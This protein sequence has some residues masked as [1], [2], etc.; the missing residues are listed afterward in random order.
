MFGWLEKN[1]PF[2]GGLTYFDKGHFIQPSYSKSFMDMV[3]YGLLRRGG[4]DK[5]MLES[6]HWRFFEIRS[7]KVLHSI[8]QRSFPWKNLWKPKVLTKVSFFL[9]EAA[10]GKILTTD[11]LQRHWI[12]VIDWCCMCIRGMGK[13]LIIY[14]YITLLLEI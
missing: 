14:F 7:Y 10:L 3:Y 9:W 2:Q 12:V 13:L 6:F 1:V 8:A 5:L 11:N 4:V